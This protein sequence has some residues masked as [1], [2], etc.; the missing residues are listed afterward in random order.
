[1]I[2]ADVAVLG[3]GGGVDDAVSKRQGRAAAVAAGRCTSPGRRRATEPVPCTVGPLLYSVG[4][5]VFRRVS[6]DDPGHPRSLPSL[7]L[8]A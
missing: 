8:T 3:G 7:E 5:A 4:A 1:M 2:G 6:D